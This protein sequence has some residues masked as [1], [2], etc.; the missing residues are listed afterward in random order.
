MQPTTTPRANRIPRIA[1]PAPSL[2]R[3]L[4][5]HLQQ[6]HLLV[7]MDRLGKQA[8]AI[9]KQLQA[10]AGESHQLAQLFRQ[11]PLLEGRRRAQR[12]ELDKVLAEFKKLRQRMDD[13]SAELQ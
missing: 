4:H 5:I 11:S 1:R 7:K 6:M 3:R 10:D 13:L 8:D 12:R 9:E 2:F